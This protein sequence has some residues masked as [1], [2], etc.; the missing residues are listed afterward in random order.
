MTE[1]CSCTRMRRRGILRNIISASTS[2][3]TPQLSPSSTLR[4]VMTSRTRLHRSIPTRP[5]SS[6]FLVS[7]SV[8]GSSPHPLFF[9]CTHLSSAVQLYTPAYT[10]PRTYLSSFTLCVACFLYFQ[11]AVRSFLSEVR[12]FDLRDSTK[13]VGRDL[14]LQEKRFTTF[15][16]SSSL[17][18]RFR[19]C[20]EQLSVL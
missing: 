19:P 9:P 12:L 3:P 20:S 18:P 6:P 5:F 11:A 14:E 17:V 16:P 13:K 10:P 2:S 8:N 4:R 7:S 15:R 1:G